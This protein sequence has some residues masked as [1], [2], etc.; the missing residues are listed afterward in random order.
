MALI[1]NTNAES[2]SAQR[3]LSVNNNKLSNSIKRLSSGLRINSAAD[4]AAGLSIATKFQAQV[5]GINQ[6]IRN[7]NNAISMVQVAEGGINTITNIL[8]RLR[9]LAVQAA[10][11]DNTKSDRLTLT[12]EAD[13][14]VEEFERVANTSEFNTQTLLDG[15]FRDKILQVGANNGQILSVSIGDLRGKAIGG[16]AEFI[17]SIGNGITTAI[18]ENLGAGEIKINGTDV[19]ATNAADDQISVLNLSSDDASDVGAGTGGSV[20]FT[21]NGSTINFIMDSSLT[22]VSAVNQLRDAIV[23]ADIT[24]VTARVFDTDN[25]LIE[26]KKGTTLNLAVHGD[27]GKASALSAFGL[28]GVSAMFGTGSAADAVTNSNG[29]SSA[30]AKAVAINQVKST[31][32]V[33]GTAVANTITANTSVDGTTDISSGEVFINGVD[34]GSVTVEDNDSTGALVTAINN[35][36]DDTGVTASVSG[37]GKLILSAADGRNIAITAE[38]TTLSDTTLGFAS[39]DR[40]NRSL[41][42][43][44]NVRLNSNETFSLSS[45]SSL[46]DLDS[47]TTGTSRSVAKDVS[48]FNVKGLKIDTQ[49]AAGAAIL[50]IDSALNDVNDLRSDLGAIQNRLEFTISNLEIAAENTSASESRIRDADFASEVAIFTKNQI[51]VQAGTAMLAQANTL[52]QIALQLLQG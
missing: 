33:M 18:N 23:S 50:T 6:A 30:I 32:T 21:I 3:N 35:K 5:R 9:E 12:K 15:S 24:N 2:L 19:A 28:N 38:T 26:A 46:A 29:E 36:T 10:S 7:S 49:E 47:A 43:R 51:L 34:I 16:R 45:S 27:I 41:L 44:G 48:T 40:T 31:T 39:T 20:T 25:I 42:F 37:A 17:A 22:A 14:L 8:Q 1:V 13:N 11:D 52:P 4:D